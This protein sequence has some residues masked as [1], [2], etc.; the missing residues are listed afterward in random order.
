MTD[1]RTPDPID[2]PEPTG[3]PDPLADADPTGQPEPTGHPD[4]IGQPEPTGHPEPIGHPEPHTPQ[5]PRRRLAPVLIVAAAALVVAASAAWAAP[6]W[7]AAVASGPVADFTDPDPQSPW[8]PDYV[9]DSVRLPHAWVSMNEALR[10][11]DRERFLSYATEEARDDLALWWDNTTKIGWETAYIVP[12]LG[13]TGGEGAFVGAELAFSARPLRGSGDADAGYRLTQGFGY[14]IT[15][16]GSGEKLR[17]SSFEPWT[18]MPWDEGPIHVAT[19]DHVVLYGWR[20]RRHWSTPRPTP[21][22][23]RP[24]RRS[25]RSPTWAARCR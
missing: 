24:S 23:R 25:M 18:S 20:T 4:P 5:V 21:P 13:S 3:H 8:L 12:A 11:K 14:D 16:T 9:P 6:R 7:P 17:I 10:D 1:P 2:R 15:T 22:R 19:R